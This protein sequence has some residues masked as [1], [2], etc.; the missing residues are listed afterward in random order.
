MIRS[1]VSLSA[2][3]T[4]GNLK[5]DIVTIGDSGYYGLH[6]WNEGS[7]DGFIQVG[8]SDGKAIAYNLVLQ[9][10]GGNILIGTTTD[11]G[12]KLQVNG[13]ERGY[14]DL[15]VDGEVSALVA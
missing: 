4:L 5:G 12:Y 1:S 7:G 14:G 8:R 3:P 10:L 13:S 2:R 9:S 6:L 11:N 15:I